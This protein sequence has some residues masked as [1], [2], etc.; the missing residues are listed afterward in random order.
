[1]DIDGYRIDVAYNEPLP[2]VFEEFIPELRK[3][4]PIFMLAEADGPRF[5]P[6]YDMTYDWRNA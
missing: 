1:V 3:I 2:E 5:H 6:L 4:K